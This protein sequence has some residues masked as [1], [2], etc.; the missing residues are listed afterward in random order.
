M[1]RL[2]KNLA[3]NV[4]AL[5]STKGLS[6]QGLADIAGVSKN[7]VI[8]IEHEDNWPSDVAIE[9]VADALGVDPSILF[10][11]EIPDKPAIITDKA[12]A[13]RILTALGL[14]EALAGDATDKDSALK[15]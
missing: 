4:K 10:A 8:R 6:L 15:K 1:G 3:R 7:Y 11:G 2:S 12:T 9:K 5:R 14:R 13:E